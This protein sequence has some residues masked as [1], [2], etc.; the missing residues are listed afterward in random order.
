MLELKA[1]G[2]VS[3][4]EAQEATDKPQCILNW[5]LL[6][7]IKSTM[8]ADSLTVFATVMKQTKLIVS[9]FGSRDP[10]IVVVGPSQGLPPSVLLVESFPRLH[11]IEWGRTGSLHEKWGS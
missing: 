9:A 10:L 11:H 7:Y 8:F 2:C 5:C 6:S 3:L 4:E 1:C